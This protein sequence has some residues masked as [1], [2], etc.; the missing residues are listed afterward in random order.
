MKIIIPL[1]LL[2]L[3][4]VINFFSGGGGKREGNWDR[5]GN[6]I[7]VSFA[8]VS[9][10]RFPFVF[11][12]ALFWNREWSNAMT[13]IWDLLIPVPDILPQNN[14]VKLTLPKVFMKFA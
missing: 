14:Y 4:S 13:G 11:F 1:I 7:F 9:V 3:I 6:V 8:W 10:Y 12:V 5:V 2:L